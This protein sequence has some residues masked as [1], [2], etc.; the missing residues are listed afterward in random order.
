MLK[1]MQDQISKIQN[2]WKVILKEEI[3]KEYF[4]KIGQFI[5]KEK[6]NKTIFPTN[7]KIFKTKYLKYK[8]IGKLFSKKKLV[9]NILKK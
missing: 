8:M 4:K 7:E 9:K 5:C 6:K 1:N 3:G 2:D